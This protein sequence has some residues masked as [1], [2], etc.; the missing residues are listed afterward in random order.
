MATGVTL[1]R[2]VK[3]LR[4]ECGHS[5]AVA[6]GQASEETLRYLLNRTQ[7]ELYVG[8]EWPFLKTHRTII[9]QAGERYYDYPAD[10]PFDRVTHI[11]CHTQNSADWRPLEKGINPGLFTSSDSDQGATS[12]PVQRWDHDADRQQIEL[13]PIPSQSTGELYVYGMKPLDPLVDNEDVCTLD[14]TL[15]VLFTAVE[16]VGRTA[17]QEADLKNQKAQR[18]LQRVLGSQG[19]RKRAWTSLSGSGRAAPVIGLDYIP[20]GYRYPG[21]N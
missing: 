12:W 13:W 17:P 8:Y 5:L 4:A 11:W 1:S 10:I 15:I 21:Q 14:G 18:H 6:Q 19:S 3:D 20:S 9:P 7:E 16:V 2:L